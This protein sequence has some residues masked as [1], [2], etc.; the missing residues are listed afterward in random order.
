[1]GDA[2]TAIVHP[3]PYSTHQAALL[4]AAI[5]TQGPILELGVGWYSTPLLHAFCAAMS[6]TLVSVESAG[7]WGEMFRARDVSGWHQFFLGP[8]PIA[9]R[10]FPGPWAVVLVDHAPPWDGHVMNRMAAV[11]A[12]A[13]CARRFVIHDTEPQSRALYGYDF[14]EM[15]HAG[16]EVIHDECPV[17][18]WTTTL[19]GR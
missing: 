18:P 3:D 12:L 19:V 16:W 10:E 15:A 5:A 7:P 4:A 1:M 6:R 14:D 9:P 8:G 17:G 2:S 13:E 11:R